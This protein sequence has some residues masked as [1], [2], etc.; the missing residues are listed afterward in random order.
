MCWGQSFQSSQEPC[1]MPCF[2]FCLFVKIKIKNEG[3][4]SHRWV[5]EMSGIESP[6]CFLFILYPILSY[7]QSQSMG[8]P[9]EAIWWWVLNQFLWRK[10]STNTILV[11]A[12]SAFE[13]ARCRWQ[14]KSRTQWRGLQ[15]KWC[16]FNNRCAVRTLWITPQVEWLGQPE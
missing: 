6:F 3:K 14:F 1:S 2:F 4:M 13:E 16:M 5:F 11:T 8:W 15:T 10:K 12:S 9:V 7:A